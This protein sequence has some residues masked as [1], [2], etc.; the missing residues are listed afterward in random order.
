MKSTVSVTEAQ[1]QLPKI[2]RQDH[3]VAVMRHDTIA[4]FVVPREKFES[5]VETVATLSSPEAMKAIKK[6]QSGKM[7]F[8]TLAEMKKDLSE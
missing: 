7:K 8:Y 1:R 4:G 6:F 5:L 2:L 3:V